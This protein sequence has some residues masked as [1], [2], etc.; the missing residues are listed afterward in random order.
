MIELSGRRSF[1]AMTGTGATAALAGCSALDGQSQTDGDGDAA[2]ESAATLTVQIRADQTELTEFQEELQAGVE[3]GNLTRTEAQQEYQSK[4]EELIRDAATAY[5]DA[6]ADDDAVSVE[7]A[8]PA[9]GLLRLT[10]PATTFVGGLEDGDLAAI[11]P[12]DYY[13]QF[14]QRQGLQEDADG[15]ATDE[16]NETA[17]D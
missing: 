10:A 6:V 2:S 16:E 1:L 3:S 9:A 15:G 11:L 4:Q 8:E 12:A 13:D 17:S 5:E 14:L 7:D